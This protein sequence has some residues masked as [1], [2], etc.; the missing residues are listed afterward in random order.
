M[1]VSHMPRRQYVLNSASGVALAAHDVVTLNDCCSFSR[2]CFDFA[3]SSSPVR[4]FSVW[5]LT[6]ALSC[7]LFAYAHT[8]Q[9]RD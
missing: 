3:T 8:E 6:V 4:M 2:I 7:A 5:L 1:A 9:G